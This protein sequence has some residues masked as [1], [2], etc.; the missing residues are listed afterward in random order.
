MIN[1]SELKMIVKSI[2]RIK[3]FVRSRSLLALALTV[4][5]TAVACGGGGLTA[6]QLQELEETKK[7]ALSAE[8]KIQE[9]KVTK[10]ELSE[11]LALK[12]KELNQLLTDK[13]LL[14]KRLKDLENLSMQE[15]EV[16]TSVV[17]TNGDD[18]S[19]EDTSS[20]DNGDGR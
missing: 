17:D 3:S 14:I 5:L 18:K 9:R 8:G 12:K 1:D 15:T 2:K 6:E 20:E 11:N 19:V 4:M 7:A 13:E 16:D 10:K